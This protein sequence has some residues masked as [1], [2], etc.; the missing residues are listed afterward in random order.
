MNTL[1][2]KIVPVFAASLIA[3]SMP[4]MAQ[5]SNEN[6]DGSNKSS[7]TRDTDLIGVDNTLQKVSEKKANL[8]MRK[9]NYEMEK[10]DISLEKLRNEAQAED[11]SQNNEQQRQ[12]EQMRNELERR[13]MQLQQQSGSLANQQTG[14]KGVAVT[15][16]Y[17]VGTNV[18][19]EVR[20]ND[21]RVV[22]TKGTKLPNGETVTKVNSSGITVKQSNGKTKSYG[23]TGNLST[24]AN[25]NQGG[26]SS[27]NNSGS[28]R[29]NAP[30]F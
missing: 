20:V 24:L 12:I 6:P 17:G 2:T 13:S 29:M 19:A 4:I 18:I 16:I 11:A 14:F 15:S 3:F 21:N 10:M 1:K 22:A 5:S 27:S 30:G 25:Y 7:V 23:V 9:I 26:V 8:E 28:S